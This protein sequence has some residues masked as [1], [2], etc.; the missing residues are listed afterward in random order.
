MT[1]RSPPVDAILIGS[2]RMACPPALPFD[3][4]A[5]RQAAGSAAQGAIGSGQSALHDMRAPQRGS[6][7]SCLARFYAAPRRCRPGRCGRL[8]AATSR[9]TSLRAGSGFDVGAAVPGPGAAG[10][11]GS[12]AAA[13]A[14][15]VHQRN[16]VRSLLAGERDPRGQPGDA[17]WTGGA[18][19]RAGSSD[20]VGRRNPRRSPPRLRECGRRREEAGDPCW[21]R[22]GH[23]DALPSEVRRE[24]AVRQ[25][26]ARLPP[27]LSASR[28]PARRAIGQ[29]AAAVVADGQQSRLGTYGTAS[30]TDR[31]NFSGLGWATTIRMPSGSRVLDEPDPPRGAGV[32]VVPA[33]PHDASEVIQLRS[34]TTVQMRH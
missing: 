14:G 18:G 32:R 20:P 19:C 11:T 13:R 24:G 3:S 17:S 29:R 27:T 1:R 9:W 10:S 16:S 4:V 34:R 33:V 31:G 22:G 5:A 30:T 25:V 28:A 12:S 7:R 23:V 6:A 8:L 21:T 15:V 26:V 2:S